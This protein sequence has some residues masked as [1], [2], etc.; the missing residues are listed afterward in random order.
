MAD[1]I[2]AFVSWSRRDR[3]IAK[4]LIS[5]IGAKYELWIDWGEQVERDSEKG[6]AQADVLF[7][8]LSESSATDL[9]CTRELAI[10][11]GWGKRIIPLLLGSEPPSTI[12]ESCRGLQFFFPEQMADL[13]AIL[14]RRRQ[15]I[16]IHTDLLVA[17]L[18]WEKVGRSTELLLKGRKLKEAV[19][20]LKASDDEA[21]IPTHLHR[22]YVLTSQV[23]ERNFLAIASTSLLGILTIGAALL[24]GFDIERRSSGVEYTFKG[25]R[26]QGTVQA[27]ITASGV[28][29]VGF[30]GLRGKT[31]N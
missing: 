3:A 17:A 4:P 11:S 29:G 2:R 12:P 15:E 27:L 22:E 28:A 23:A 5:Q 18:R 9:G 13:D 8:L 20:W 30:L 19:A 7:F 24:V 14:E 16:I 6:I 25:D 21:P 31:L 10:A 1:K 26:I